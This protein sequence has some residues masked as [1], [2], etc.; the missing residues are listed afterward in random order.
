MTVKDTKRYLAII[1]AHGL[2][3]ALYV[4]IGDSETHLVVKHRITGDIR[5]LDK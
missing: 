4:V 1:K 3:P 5:A 2:N